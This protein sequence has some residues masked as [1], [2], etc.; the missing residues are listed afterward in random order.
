M[1]DPGALCAASSASA[2]C[3]ARSTSRGVGRGWTQPAVE[4]LAFQR[5]HQIAMAAVLADMVNG[6]DK[7]W[8]RDA[9]ARASRSKRREVALAEK[10]GEEILIATCRPSRGSCADTARPYRPRRAATDFIGTEPQSSGYDMAESWVRCSVLGARKN[11]GIGICTKKLGGPLRSAP[12]SGSVR[13]ST[14]RKMPESESRVPEP[15]F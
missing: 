3:T 6:G 7:G 12:Q 1:D 13:Y 15:Q 4:R 10:A 5:S 11:R 8:F 14:T 2:I 9:I